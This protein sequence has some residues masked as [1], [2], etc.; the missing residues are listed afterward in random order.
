M[1]KLT[2][3]THERLTEVLDY[4]P[5]TGVFVW[6]VRTSNSVKVGDRA[7]V[8]GSKGYRLIGL[9]GTKFQT[10][11]L[12]WF[13]VHAE[14]PSADVVPID[15]NL[16]RPAIDNLK[17][18]SRVDTARLRKKLSTNTSG[19]KGVSLTTSGKWQASITWDYKQIN[20]GNKYDTAEDASE[21]YEE[22][23][24]RLMAAASDG[25][26]VRALT[27]VQLWRR[28]RAAWREIKRSHPDH[29]W[30]SF[31]DFCQI[32]L[33]VPR[34]RWAMVP[35]DVTKPIGPA[36]YR[37]SLPADAEV[38]SGTA[39]Y[40]KL[41]NDA[42]RDHL[43]SRQMVRDYGIDAAVYA[44]M[45]AEQK[46]VCAICEQPE[47]K[48]EKGHVR[49]LSVDHNHKTGAVRGLL[50]SNCNVAIGLFCDDVAVLQRAI[51]YLRKHRGD[52]T[53]EPS[54]IGGALGSGG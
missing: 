35:I 36:N 47:T 24:R 2:K 50:C 10:T 29:C 23:S 18:V 41:S 40:R 14:W 34:K 51:G 7:G 53:F 16:D 17:N 12:A 19:F 43:R 8:V 27:Q 39:E 3:L 38:R 52:V 11:R 6:K 5:A 31:D 20:L 33:D 1:A 46:G 32:I 42:N 25:D 37:W 49:Q 30:G 4:D 22:A 9:D 15:G 45:L 48:I 13:Y 44:R 28:Q 26:R 21:V 54:V